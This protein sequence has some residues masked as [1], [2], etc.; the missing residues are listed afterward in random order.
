[1]S[2]RATRGAIHILVALT[3]SAL[4]LD[5]APPEHSGGML[6][7]NGTASALGRLLGP[8]LVVLFPMSPR[9][10]FLIAAAFVGMLTLASALALRT[11]E[12]GGEGVRG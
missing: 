1:M 10:V 5:L 12:K 3:L 4:I 8:A 9:R 6:G 2:T 7:L 11:P